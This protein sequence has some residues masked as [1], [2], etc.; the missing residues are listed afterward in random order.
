MRVDQLLPADLL[1][2]AAVEALERGNAALAVAVISRE[3]E[4]ID[5]GDVEGFVALLA[6]GAIAARMAG[7]SHQATRWSREAVAAS[8]AT[9]PACGVLARA[10]SIFTSANELSADGAARE[11]VALEALLSAVP[12]DRIET[13]GRYAA[14]FAWVVAGETEP[15]RRALGELR[16]LPASRALWISARSQVCE[17]VIDYLDTNP[18]G[19]ASVLDLL[20]PLTLSAGSA[21]PLA[22]MWWE[23]AELRHRLG[24]HD[25]AWDA[26]ARAI[27]ASGVRAADGRSSFAPGVLTWDLSI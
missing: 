15:A 24:D 7:D 18:E 12:G 13:F 9:P 8:E 16:A 6:Q 4:A 22:S 17:A 1:L 25:Q 2:P 26:A 20:Q 5:S 10:V 23:I 3:C 21:L 27:D 11:A 14:L 19:V